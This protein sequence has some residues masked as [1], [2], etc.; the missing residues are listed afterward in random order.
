LVNQ[1]DENQTSEKERKKRKKRKK[2][3]EKINCEKN[4]ENSRRI[5]SRVLRTE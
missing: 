2:G 3:G 4:N 5:K 1:S